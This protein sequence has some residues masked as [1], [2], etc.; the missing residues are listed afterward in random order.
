MNNT[1]DTSSNGSGTGESGRDGR[2]SP[3]RLEREVNQARAAVGNTLRELSARL[4]PGELLDQAISMVREHGGDLGRNLGGQVKSNPLPVILTTVGV[5]W[6]MM[7]SGNKGVA[8][9]R[10]T[11]DAISDQDGD[12]IMD[13]LGNT[14]A[15]SRDKATAL[16]D[17]VQGATA[18]AKES[19]K[20]AREGL[21]QFYRDQP[22]IAGSLGIAIGAALGGL[23][24]PTQVEDDALGE[25]S[26]RS[27]AA[28]KSKATRKYDEVR[29]SARSE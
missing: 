9:S 29:D 28:A 26:D 8:Q 6:M 23:I 2:K 24:P 5:S 17:Q 7:S 27:V 19:A 25:V 3:Q 18:N 13:A 20:N 12:G 4:S 21:V 10:G 14:A 22:L 16:G 15:K 11:S 1:S